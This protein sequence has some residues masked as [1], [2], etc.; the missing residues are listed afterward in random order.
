MWTAALASVQ[1]DQDS[2]VSRSAAESTGYVPRAIMAVPLVH[3][4]DCVGVIEFLDRADRTGSELRTCGPSPWT[5][6]P[7]R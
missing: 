7:P 6:P 4:G 1:V 3:D 2:K 5:S